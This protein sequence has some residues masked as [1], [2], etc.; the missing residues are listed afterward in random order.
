[1]SLSGLGVP[2]GKSGCDRIDRAV[3]ETTH[4]IAL[5]FSVMMELPVLLHQPI[6]FRPQ[7]GQYFKLAE[8]SRRREA[9]VR[10]KAPHALHL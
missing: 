10:T 5:T 6:T 2:G 4:G 7:F 1:M 8:Q 3:R 9:S